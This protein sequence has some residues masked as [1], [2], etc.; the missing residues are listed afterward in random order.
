[1]STHDGRYSSGIPL[2]IH[3]VVF[4][5]QLLVEEVVFVMLEEVLQQHLQ[6]VRSLMLWADL[7]PRQLTCTW[8]L[9]P[10]AGEIQIISGVSLTF[11]SPSCGVL[12]GLTRKTN[13]P[14]KIPMRNTV[15]KKMMTQR[16]TRVCWLSQWSII[17]FC[18]CSCLHSCP[19]TT[20]AALDTMIRW[21]ARTYSRGSILSMTLRDFGTHDVVERDET[22]HDDADDAADESG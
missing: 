4:V 2:L 6:G 20:E 17:M 7:N 22:E 15:R 1:V 3:V 11:D 18:V 5:V 19:D 21:Y 9:S 16:T 10:F 12:E 8:Y 13:A 14:T